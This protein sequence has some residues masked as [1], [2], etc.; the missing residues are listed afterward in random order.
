MKKSL[1]ILIL[2]V[3]FT[4]VFTV[5]LVKSL[6][7][8]STNNYI[9]DLICPL[10][11]IKY[12][13]FKQQYP[14]VKKNIPIYIFYHLCPKSK[15]NTDHLIIIDEQINDLI[16]SGLYKQCEKIFYGCS[17]EN[18]DVFLDNY[19]NKYSKFKKLDKAILPNVMCYENMTINSMI[20]FAK[21]SKKGFYGLYFHTK[22]TT[23]KSE[24]QHNWRK[25]MSYFLIKNYKLCVDT[26]NRGFNTC[27]VEYVDFFIKH[28]SG[29]FFWFNSNYV[30]K[31]DYITD[32]NNRYNAEFVLF[33]KYEKNKHVSIYKERYFSL[34]NSIVDIG[35]YKFKV[36]YDNL[37]KNY[38]QNIDVA[39][40]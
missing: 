34:P 39:I 16:S 19:L 23:S 33:S 30:K 24:N 13:D 28:Y 36:D 9:V 10:N 25:F 2:I 12:G 7:N 14:V 40:I 17:C 22:G 27:G 8:K 31:L 11:Y 1:I 26:L 37:P 3:V 20:E 38:I 32:I 6:Q 35:L 18:C 4:V 15:N 29:N 5:V 21:N